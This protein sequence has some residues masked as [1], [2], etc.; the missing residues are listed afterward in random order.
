MASMIPSVDTTPM[1]ERLA[2]VVVA[3]FG[4]C[5]EYDGAKLLCTII[6]NFERSKFKF[7]IIHL[8]QLFRFSGTATREIRRPRGLG[9][10]ANARVR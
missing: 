5:F 9:L 1:M 4:R 10:L 6:Y 8:T 2:G 7:P 3:V